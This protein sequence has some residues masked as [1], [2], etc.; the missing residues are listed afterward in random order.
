MH[1]VLYLS[2]LLLFFNSTMMKIRPALASALLPKLTLRMAVASAGRPEDLL[3][4][5]VAARP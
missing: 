4:L 5:P 2:R 1:V 3:P